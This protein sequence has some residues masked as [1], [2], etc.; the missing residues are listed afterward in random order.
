MGVPETEGPEDTR[1]FVRHQATGGRIRMKVNSRQ[2]AFLPVVV[3][4]ALIVATPLRC[5]PT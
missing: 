1:I 3:V 2:V 4:T 5:L